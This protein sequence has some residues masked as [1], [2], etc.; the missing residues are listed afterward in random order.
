[1]VSEKNLST[2]KALARMELQG[3]VRGMASNALWC[4]QPSV[5]FYKHL[6]DQPIATAAFGLHSFM[7]TKTSSERRRGEPSSDAPVEAR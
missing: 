1:M 5:E 2:I 3:C 4:V 6:S 7:A